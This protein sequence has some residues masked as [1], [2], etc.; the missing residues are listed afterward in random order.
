M[1][2]FQKQNAYSN[3]VGKFDGNRLLCLRASHRDNIKMDL[4]VWRCTGSGLGSM[5]SFCCNS[6]ITGNFLLTEYVKTDIWGMENI[7][8]ETPRNFNCTTFMIM[9]KFCLAENWN[10]MIAPPS[11]PTSGVSC[12]YCSATIHHTLPGLSQTVVGQYSFHKL[13]KSGY[14]F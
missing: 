4:T 9:I 12:L 14:T 7:T 6:S 10:Q 1:Y 13:R 5:A 8:Y 11:P 2:A 3:L